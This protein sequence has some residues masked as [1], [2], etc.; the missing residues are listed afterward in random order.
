MYASQIIFKSVNRHQLEGMGDIGLKE[1]LLS[2]C[3]QYNIFCG[4]RSYYA[5]HV[6]GSDAV[7]ES[8][9]QGF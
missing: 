7:I 8:Y 4:P 5:S 1:D 6:S 3:F 9:D 2:I